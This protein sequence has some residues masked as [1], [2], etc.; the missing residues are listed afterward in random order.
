MENQAYHQN[1]KPLYNA[2]GQEYSAAVGPPRM[3]RAV[4][5]WI[6]VGVF[7]L[8]LTLGILIW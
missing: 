4:M 5:A 2:L 3:S 1:G 8:G 6:M 7:V